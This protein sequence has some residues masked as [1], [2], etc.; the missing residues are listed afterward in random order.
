MDPVNPLAALAALV[1]KRVESQRVAGKRPA[2]A[3]S[4]SRA[5]GSSAQ[6]ESRAA[7]PELQ[8]ELTIALQAVE[9]D[10]PNAR[11]KKLHLFV[12]RVLRW[13]FGE[14]MLNDPAFGQL[15]DDV[16]GVL[17]ANEQVAEMLGALEAEGETASRG[18]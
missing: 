4:T 11:R 8:R 7:L 10:D 12:G 2:P 13:Q 1:R 5:E 15:I 17:A 6:L 14:A 18:R 9:A 16:C 3:G